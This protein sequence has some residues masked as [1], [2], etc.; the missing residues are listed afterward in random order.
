MRARRGRID[1]KWLSERLDAIELAL[2]RGADEEALRL[3]FDAAQSPLRE[4][5]AGPRIER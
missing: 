3:Y 5:V 2:D 1:A 4:G